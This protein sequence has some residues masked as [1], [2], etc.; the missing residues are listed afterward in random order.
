MMKDLDGKWKVTILSGPLWLIALNIPGDVKIIENGRGHNVA[1]RFFHWGKF[2]VLKDET[3]GYVLKYND[4]EI[5]DRVY[6]L[7]NNR[8]VIKGQFLLKGKM[9]GTF[10]MR[11]IK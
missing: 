2:V 8:D 4:G 6:F 7:S 3:G 1:G 11:R 5:V 9:T 10:E